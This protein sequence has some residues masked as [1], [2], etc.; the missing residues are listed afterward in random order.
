[1]KSNKKPHGVRVKNPYKMIEDFPR[2]VFLFKGLGEIGAKT[3]VF[4]FIICLSF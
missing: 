3:L 2:E 4:T 1:M